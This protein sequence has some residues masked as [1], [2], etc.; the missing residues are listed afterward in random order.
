MSLGIIRVLTTTDDRVLGEHGRLLERDYGIRSLSQCIPDQPRGIHDAQTEALAIP[1]I[2]A[3]RPI[4]QCSDQ[5]FG[6]GLTIFK[7]G[8]ANN[9]RERIA[10][11]FD[12]FC[13]AK[14]VTKGVKR[15]LKM[16]GQRAGGD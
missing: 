1:K 13:Q 3:L 7:G 9:K 11:S 6:Y 14:P 10:P 5:G 12:A 2:L 16:R 15:G 8:E 4:F